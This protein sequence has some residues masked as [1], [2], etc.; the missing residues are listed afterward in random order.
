MDVEE[1]DEMNDV[2]NGSSPPKDNEDSSNVMVIDRV[3]ELDMVSPPGMRLRSGK[4]KKRDRSDVI[5]EEDLPSLSRKK[6]HLNDDDDDDKG[7]GNEEGNRNAYSQ[8]KKKKKK[9][10][11]E[12]EVKTPGRFLYP[13]QKRADNEEKEKE[14]EKEKILVISTSSNTNS[15]T[16]QD[17]GRIIHN[18]N[19]KLSKQATPSTSIAV[20]AAVSKAPVYQGTMRLTSADA[21]T[22]SVR[23]TDSQNQQPEEKEDRTTVSD[24]I[25]ERSVDECAGEGRNMQISSYKSNFKLFS[26]VIYI[27]SQF[28]LIPLESELIYSKFNAMN[29]DTLSTIDVSKQKIASRKEALNQLLSETKVELRR[30][31]LAVKDHEYENSRLQH[32]ND[33]ESKKAQTMELLQSQIRSALLHLTSNCNFDQDVMLDNAIDLSTVEELINRTQASMKSWSDSLIE[34]KSLFNKEAELD[35]YTTAITSFLDISP[36]P[37]SFVLDEEVF[38]FPSDSCFDATT[39]AEKDEISNT[40]IT[41]ISREVLHDVNH[42]MIHAAEL[43]S[44]ML[45]ENEY[46]VSTLQS[47]VSGHLKDRF[48][49]E[50]SLNDNRSKI[51]DSETQ[52]D[53]V[54][55]KKHLHMIKETIDDEIE[56]DRCDQTGLKDYALDS[57]VIRS[58]DYA[59]SPSIKDTLSLWHRFLALM[60]IKFYGFPAEAALSVTHPRDGLGQCWAFARDTSSRVH[61]SFGQGILGQYA[62]LTIQLSDRI[63]VKSVAIEHPLRL[64]LNTSTAIKSFRVF[65]FADNGM[66]RPWDLGSFQ[67]DIRKYFLIP[68]CMFSKYT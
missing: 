48:V 58:G 67:F 59:T 62:T 45:K 14:E 10:K 27:I 65:G 1:M 60:K 15:I 32:S 50:K 41:M 12:E 38:R 55:Y 3:M 23:N 26:V 33:E 34:L 2:S 43:S 46:F 24:K 31:I 47:T 5:S 66:T 68:L 63:H 53:L 21:S 7:D 25:E 64:E 19:N 28:I 52:Q 57:Q 49:I 40:D 29:E 4:K 17:V 6:L 30:E 8:K 13:N 35:D 36:V 61:D 39:N 44:R 9:K 51:A 54:S 18:D 16:S 42:D 37:I 22:S 11:E 56:K 20:F